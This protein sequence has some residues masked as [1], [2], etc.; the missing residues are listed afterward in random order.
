MTVRLHRHGRTRAWLGR[1]FGG[2]AALGDRALRH[3][4]HV[5]GAVVLF[6]YLLPAGFFGVVSN[7]VALLLALSAVLAI[8]ALRHIAR[9][10]LPTIRPYERKRVASFAF[11]A[12]ALVISVLVFPKP[13][14][15]AVVLGTALVDPLAGILRLRNGAHLTPWIAPILAYAGIAAAV[16][17]WVGGWSWGSTI[18]AG[19]GAAV[20]AVV[21][22]RPESKWYDDD[23]GMTLV[24]GAVL[25]VALWLWPGFPSGP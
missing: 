16:F 21:V 6:Y 17:R 8:E 7:E 20:I 1:R 4:L 10:E 12:V 23:L 14:A 11:F 19:V 24:P 5:A 2:D 18:A 22:E 15:V 9:V 3:L 13:I 25:T